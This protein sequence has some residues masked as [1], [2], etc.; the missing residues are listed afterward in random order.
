MGGDAG[1]DPFNY[2]GNRGLGREGDVVQLLSPHM[3]IDDFPD[4][5]DDGDAAWAEGFPLVG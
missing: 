3:P 4:H 5:V 1:E 2:G